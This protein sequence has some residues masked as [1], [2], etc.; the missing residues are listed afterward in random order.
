M[1]RRA[2]GQQVMHGQ[3][4]H[5]VFLVGTNQAGAHQAAAVHVQRAA[6]FGQGQGAHIAQG[7][8]ELLQ[9]QVC[10]AVEALPGPGTVGVHPAAQDGVARQQPVEG[11]LQ[12]RDLQ[13]AAQLQQQGDVVVDRIGLVQV[14]GFEGVDEPD[15]FLVIGQRQPR[16]GRRQGADLGQGQGRVQL[17]GAD[18]GLRGF[19]ET[20]QQALEALRQAFDGAG[21]EQRGGVRQAAG[22]ARA[23]FVDMQRQVVLGVVLVRRQELQVQ[24]RQ[25]QLPA[26]TA[27]V[28]VEHGLEHRAVAG[29][30]RRLEGFDDLF[31]RRVL[32]AGGL[33]HQLL[34]LLQHLVE[35]RVGVQA[36]A[37]GQGVDEEADQRL[38]VLAV[39]VGGHG[40]DHHVLLAADPAQQDGPG[41]HQGHERG[42]RA[43]LGE[44]GDSAGQ[45]HRQVEA[46]G[47]A[48]VALH[49]RPWPVGGQREQGRG[50]GQVTAP[51]LHVLAQAFALQVLALPGGVVGVLQGQGGQGI[52]LAGAERLV[53]RGEFLDQHADRPAVG[54]DVVL[55]DQQPV[56]IVGQA[57]QA[58]TDQ[59]PVQ[60]VER[61]SR[62]ALA[63]LGRLFFGLLPGQVAQVVLHQA[64][65]AVDRGDDLHWLLAVTAEG[66]AQAFMA[67]HQ[68]IQGGLE[69]ALVKAA[70]QHQRRR[71]VVGGA[72][73][74]VQLIEEPQALL[75]ERQ[76]QRTFAVH[77][78]HVVRGGIDG[79]RGAALL[80]QAQQCGTFQLVETIVM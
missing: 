11:A 3:G 33:Q 40:A 74:R 5:G 17:Q 1:H 10:R 67:G 7:A 42:R 58:A 13:F 25:L 18:A 46:Q 6:G 55:G 23:A 41:G 79:P 21:V 72:G 50:A 57:Q 12:R 56:F 44:A 30:A 43:G 78:N 60:Q 24:P 64:E 80:E 22:Q 47:L 36:H 51:E 37:Q 29:A 16:R 34:D 48:T 61:G 73:R 8:L 52:G 62:F 2:V 38:H 71:H 15:P 66:G 4:Q 35:G 28:G 70:A 19:G 65:T 39:A 32:A 20:A 54:D 59:R 53:Q 45:C 26:G 63:Q 76:R 68:A 49:R 14:A 31:E 27:G 77:G 69:C 75:S 9:H